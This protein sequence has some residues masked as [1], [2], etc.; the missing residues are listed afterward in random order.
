M[1]FQTGAVLKIRD[2]LYLNFFK[3]HNR[4][5]T[6]FHVKGN[7]FRQGHSVGTEK[8]QMCG[9]V[10]DCQENRGRGTLFRSKAVQ[11]VITR[12]PACQNVVKA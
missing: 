9:A 5:R 1:I 2:I 3:R 10:R 4:E 12:F 6:D 8:P 11:P 7:V